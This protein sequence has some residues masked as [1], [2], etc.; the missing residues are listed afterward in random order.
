MHTCSSA[1]LGYITR[2][3]ATQLA[4][5]TI[6]IFL[7]LNGCLL[8]NP[9]SRHMTPRSI[10]LSMCSRRTTLIPNHNICRGSRYKAAYPYYIPKI[11]HGHGY[12]TNMAC[13]LGIEKDI[14]QFTT[15]ITSAKAGKAGVMLPY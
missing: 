2:M 14:R 10:G 11:V 12:L 6:I 1:T 8:L 3:V 4:T 15:Y 13:I 5:N 7:L 9:H